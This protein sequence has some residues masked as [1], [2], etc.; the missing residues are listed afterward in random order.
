MKRIFGRSTDGVEGKDFTTFIVGSII[1]ENVEERKEGEK[2][3][4]IDRNKVCVPM[5]A[6]VIMHSYMHAFVVP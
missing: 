2:D 6:N 5:Y 3:E 4:K 1:I